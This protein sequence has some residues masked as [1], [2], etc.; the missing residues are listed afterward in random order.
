MVK[1]GYGT[2]TFEILETRLDTVRFKPITEHLCNVSGS[3]LPCLRGGGGK[4]CIS[5]RPRRLRVPMFGEVDYHRQVEADSGFVCV[6]KYI[7]I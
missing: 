1:T 7:F 2:V 4:L 5:T 6:T 3:S